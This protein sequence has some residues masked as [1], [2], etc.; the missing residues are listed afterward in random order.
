MRKESGNEKLITI[1]EA[2]HGEKTA[3]EIF[4]LNMT[5]ATV[6][7]FTDPCCMVIGL[8]MAVV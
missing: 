4:V 5:R 8:Y 6:L 2:A 7:F 1:Y 3:R